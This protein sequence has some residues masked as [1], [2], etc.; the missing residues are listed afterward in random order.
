MTLPKLRWRER[1]LVR[2][3]Y[4]P[5]AVGE[6]ERRFLAAIERLVRPGDRLLDAGCGS[7]R[8]FTYDLRGRADLIV[9][10]DLTSDVGQNANIN[11]PLRASLTALPFARE[12]FDLIICKHVLEHLDEPESAFHELARVLRPR[13]RLLILT[14]NRFH[15]VPLLASLLPASCQ[16][17]VAS[18]RGLTPEEVHP[19]LYRANTPRRLRRLARQAGLRIAV[20]RLFE[21]P[22]VYLAFHP[23]AFALG[24]AYERLVNRLEALAP[25]R[26]NLLAVLRKP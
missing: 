11:A 19:A 24:V 25:L 5:S 3:F 22:P 7:G 18:G 20:L 2:R 15:Y 14:P 17:L 13:G 4:G 10:V 6:L 9:G 23:L 8:L 16:R 26:V 1:E 12:T 21:T